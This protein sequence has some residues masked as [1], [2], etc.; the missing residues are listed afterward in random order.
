MA[1][2]ANGAS[3]AAQA[4]ARR[5]IVVRDVNDGFKLGQPTNLADNGG[6]PCSLREGMIAALFI[7]AAGAQESRSRVYAASLAYARAHPE[8]DCKGSGGGAAADGSGGG[9]GGGTA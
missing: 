2:L 4:T 8:D 3:A 1:P 5:T 9:S 7:A 6:R